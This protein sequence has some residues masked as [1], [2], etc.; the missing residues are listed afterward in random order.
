MRHTSS[1]RIVFGGSCTIGLPLNIES[2]RRRRMIG[3]RIA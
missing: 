3:A 2:F 1:T